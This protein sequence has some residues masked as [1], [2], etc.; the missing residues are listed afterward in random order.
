MLQ[1]VEQFPD[2]EILSTLSTQLSWSH[3]IELL[4]LKSSE[5]RLFYVQQAAGAHLGVRDLLAPPLTTRHSLPA[6]RL[7]FV[8]I[9]AVAAF[10]TLVFRGKIQE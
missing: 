3:F 4:P 5:A 2:F 9:E 1:F 8:P 7:S 6:S 10:Y